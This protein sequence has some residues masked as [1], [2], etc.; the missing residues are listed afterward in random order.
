MKSKLPKGRPTKEDS[1][2]LRAEIF[3][4]LLSRW[5]RQSG[6]SLLQHREVEQALHIN[7]K[8]VNTIFRDIADI[9]ADITLSS[10]GIR[11]GRQTYYHDNL[12]VAREWKDAIADKLVGL[13]PASA[14]LACSA[15]TT[16]ACCVKRLIEAG[17]YHVI[18]TNNMGVID[19]LSCGDISNLI[20]TGGEYKPGIHGCVGDKVVEAFGEARCGA[21][22]IGVSGINEEGELFVRHFEE[23]AVDKQIVRSVTNDIFILA[24]IGKLA[25]VDT[26]RF[27]SIS[28]LL[29]DERRPN[30]K[31]YLITNPCELLSKEKHL[32][33]SA[34][35]VYDALR[36]IDPI[37]VKVIT[38][39]SNGNR[40]NRDEGDGKR[41]GKRRSFV[42]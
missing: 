27:T 1:S 2:Q 32:Q 21:A 5:R 8:T 19:Q 13:I 6:G 38:A 40:S 35:K 23:I 15:G 36:K 3:Q 17:D 14:T 24:H 7:R 26:W 33:E 18:V 34:E 20:F 9:S 10:E 29:Q 16:V 12:P 4:M 28:D 31:I 41:L 42:D 37:R 22:L 30:L 11:A 25:Q 39:T